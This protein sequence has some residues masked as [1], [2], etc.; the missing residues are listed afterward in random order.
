MDLKNIYGNKNPV[1]VIGAGKF[2]IAIIKLLAK[3]SHVL[4]YVRND[5]AKQR[6]LKAQE[7]L[8]PI[9]PKDNI[10]ITQDISEI[11]EKC[12]V[13][14]PIIP[15]INF[16]GMIRE[17][18][19]Y[20]DSKRHIII[21]GTKG[22]DV[23][24]P[25]KEGVR[26]FIK[27]SRDDVK[28]MSRIIKEETTIK[29]VGCIAGPNLSKEILANHPAATVIASSTKKVITIGQKLLRSEFFQVYSNKDILG[30]ELCGALKN[31]IALA[32]GALKGLDY[33]E[34]AKA[35]LI[36]RGIIEMLYIGKF[37]GAS[38][39]PFLGLAGIGDLVATCSSE[40]SRNHRVGFRLA[41]GENLDEITKDIGEAIEGINTVKVINN[42]VRSYKIK[43]PITETMYKILFKDMSI[44]KALKYLM[45]YPS[46]DSDV[47]FI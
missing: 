40:L 11:A 32:A 31:I 28:T 29:K 24:W 39:K 14:F 6:V 22:F 18:N 16:R 36:S 46:L 30:V 21:H 3:N 41:K 2:G 4:V 42:L 10:K 19:P 9:L 34:N 15:A 8:N 38:I 17:I 13:I 23:R 43:L 1:G 7:G 25:K 26:G 45:N 35:L 5:L 27:L 12:E 44:P 20:L 47:D 37:M 33:G